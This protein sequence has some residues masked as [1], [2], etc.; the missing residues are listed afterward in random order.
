[1]IETLFMLKIYTY[2]TGMTFTPTPELELE[3]RTA[4]LTLVSGQFCHSNL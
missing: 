3:A 4:E 2:F 1:M